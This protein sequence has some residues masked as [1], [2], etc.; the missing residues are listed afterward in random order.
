[1]CNAIPVLA[2]SPLSALQLPGDCPLQGVDCSQTPN[3]LNVSSVAWK[4][5]GLEFHYNASVLETGSDACN[6]VQHET[7]PDGLLPLIVSAVL[8]NGNSH[9]WI[10]VSK[11]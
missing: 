7:I 2:C 11:H 8:D 6:M 10:L 4:G 9:F 5:E 3:A 1:M